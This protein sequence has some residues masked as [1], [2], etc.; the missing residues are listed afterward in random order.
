M[1]DGQAP[2]RDR[3]LRGVLGCEQRHVPDFLTLPCVTRSGLRELQQHTAEMRKVQ[4]GAGAEI[5]KARPVFWH[6]P[7]FQK[8]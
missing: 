7:S 4:V 8:S 6:G 5:R 2:V 3:M 1:N